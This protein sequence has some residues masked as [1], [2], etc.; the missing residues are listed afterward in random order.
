MEF[1]LKSKLKNKLK[2]KSYRKKK[3]KEENLT[4]KNKIRKKRI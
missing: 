3:T 4:L 2:M 1:I